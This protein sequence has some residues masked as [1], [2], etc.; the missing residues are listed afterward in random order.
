[1]VTYIYNNLIIEIY[2][3]HYGMFYRTVDIENY[4]GGTGDS[5]N[6]IKA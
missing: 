4:H 1:M 3:T 5:A 2:T 6:C